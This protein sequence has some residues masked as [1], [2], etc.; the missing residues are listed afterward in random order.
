MGEIYFYN[1]SVLERNLKLKNVFFGVSCRCFIVA[2]LLVCSGLLSQESVVT[3]LDNIY[4]SDGATI[5]IKNG[6]TEAT[7]YITQNSAKQ[8]NT[9]TQN[10]LEKQKEKN[11]FFLKKIRQKKALAEKKIRKIK[12]QDHYKIIFKYSSESE[13]RISVSSYF[14]K[15]ANNSSSNFLS[16]FINNT[17]SLLVSCLLVYQEKQNVLYEFYNSKT[18]KSYLF[19]RPPPVSYF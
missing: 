9:I 3:G 18:Y 4:L 12:E 2:F 14:S 16:K 13:E 5:V 7:T 6:E 8:K 1:N 15:V 10:N 11:K 19:T 17:K